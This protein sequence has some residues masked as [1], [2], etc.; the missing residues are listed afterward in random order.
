MKDLP[1]QLR[2][3]WSFREELSVEDGIILKGPRVVV[4]NS[5]HEYVLGKLHEGRHQGSTKTKL[6]VHAIVCIG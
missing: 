4:P 5:M 2:P 6:Y 3:Y 1:S